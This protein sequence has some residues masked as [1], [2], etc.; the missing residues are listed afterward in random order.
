[1]QNIKETEQYKKVMA[2]TAARLVSDRV[3]ALEKQ[4]YK[5]GRFAMKAGGI[6]QVRE[7]KD[8]YRIQIGYGVGRYNYAYAVVL[9]K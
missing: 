4:G 3:K 2:H 1:M 7:M 6:G 9:P 5:I 8:H